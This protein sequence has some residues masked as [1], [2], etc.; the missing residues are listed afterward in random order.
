MLL[1][2]LPVF[3]KLI[4]IQFLPLQERLQRTPRKT[5][6]DNTCVDLHGDLVLALLGVEMRW[7]V[8]VL[9]HVDDDSQKPRD[10]WHDWPPPVVWT[11]SC[12]YGQSNSLWWRFPSK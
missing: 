12:S 9:Q 7:S 5:T 2:E 6:L 1:S 4:V 11:A 3:Q 10:F 8:I